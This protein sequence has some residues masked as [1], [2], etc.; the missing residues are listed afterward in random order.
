MKYKEWDFINPEKTIAE[1]ERGKWTGWLFTDC[2]VMACPKCGA[3]KFHHCVTPRGR[4][5]WPPHEE[6]TKA[7]ID[8]GYSANKRDALTI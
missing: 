8:T 6:R 2:S 3:S 1:L 4:K 5:A 7:L